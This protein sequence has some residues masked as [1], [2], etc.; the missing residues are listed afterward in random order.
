MFNGHIF[1]RGQSREV[2][3]L[4]IFHKQNIKLTKKGAGLVINLVT[5][6]MIKKKILQSI[7]SLVEFKNS[8]RLLMNPF[9]RTLFGPV[10]RA[11]IA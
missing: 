1:N 11:P 6:T 7:V 4:L 8:Y 9:F 10:V 5:I 3:T 2:M